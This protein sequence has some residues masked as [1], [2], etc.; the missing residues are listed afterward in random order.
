MADADPVGDD[1]AKIVSVE[2]QANRVNAFRVI[3]GRGNLHIVEAGW[4]LSCHGPLQ[5]KRKTGCPSGYRPPPT[6]PEHFWS[7]GGR[8]CVAMRKVCERL[9]GNVE[10]TQDVISK[11]YAQETKCGVCFQVLPLNIR[12]NGFL[13][14]SECYK[15]LHTTCVQEWCR[16]NGT[17]KCPF[18]RSSVDQVSS[19]HRHA[20]NTS[21]MLPHHLGG[22]ETVGAASTAT[23]QRASPLWRRLRYLWYR[24]GQEFLMLWYFQEGVVPHVEDRGH[25][26]PASK[27]SNHQLQPRVG[28]NVSLVL[29][30]CMCRL[31][32]VDTNAELTAKFS[33]LLNSSS[34]LA[35]Q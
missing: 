32:N 4:Y 29:S 33:A 16:H 22:A 35:G 13:V 30:C 25:P 6:M 1:N 17:A 7:E 26:G 14:C 31:P 3:D 20:P 21:H 18:C 34:A 5:G 23:V 2:C 12:A 24:N 19:V 11:F 10:L 8:P 15:P 28:C 9:L 27:V